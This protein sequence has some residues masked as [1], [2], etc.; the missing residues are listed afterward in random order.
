MHIEPVS[1]LP[2]SDTDG[3]RRALRETVARGNPLVP[4]KH[5]DAYDKGE[6]I[7]SKYLGIKTPGEFN[8][9]AR[10]WDL[11]ERD[12]LYEISGYKDGPIGRRVDRHDHVE[13]FPAG[14][15]LETVIDRMIAILQSAATGD[16]G[17]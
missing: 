4:K 11:F 1:V 14:T 6:R 16:T 12:G 5:L 3:L 9:R 17:H 7:T 10:C 15:S 2:V 8:R 13:P